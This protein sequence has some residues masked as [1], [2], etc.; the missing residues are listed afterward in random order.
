M[1]QKK[2]ERLIANRVWNKAGND[3]DDDDLVTEA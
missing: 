1:T 3:D 2:G